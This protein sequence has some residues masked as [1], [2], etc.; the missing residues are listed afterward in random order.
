VTWIANTGFGY[1]DRDELAY[2]E[3][4]SL[5]WIQQLMRGSGD[6]LR[7]ASVSG[8]PLG[9]SI[10]E[11][12][13]QAKLEY[14]NR[15]GAHGFTPYDE[16][17]LGE[18]TLYG[19]PMLRIA[20]PEDVQIRLPRWMDADAEAALAQQTFIS[21]T[22]GLLALR[23]AFTLP[24][25]SRTVTNG[26]YFHVNDET[27]PIPGMP[28]FPRTSVTLAVAPHPG[29]TVIL[30]GRE[31][32]ARGAFL[33]GGR[34]HTYPNVDPAVA[35][36]VTDTSETLPEPRY[37]FAEWVPTSWNLVN[38]VRTE[39]GVQQRL[40]L[41]PAQYSARSAL[42]GT[43]RVFDALTY[44]VYYSDTEDVGPPS[45]WQIQGASVGGRHVVTAE[46]TDLSGVVR[47]AV[48]YTLGEGV[49]HVVDMARTL[50]DPDLWVGEVPDAAE[51]AYFVQAV[52]SAGNVGV[53][54]N[55]GWYFRPDEDAP[56]SQITEVKALD[57]AL[58]SGR[59]AV[60]WT[61]AD[62]GL[63]V[64]TVSL[65]VK[66]GEDATWHDTRQ[67]A[68]DRDGGRFVF[69]PTQGAGTYYFATQAMDWAGNQEP[70]PVGEGMA[71]YDWMP[72]NTL[73]LPVIMRD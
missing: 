5:L 11:A 64:A 28:I 63:G 29:G 8:D 4:L 47:V 1:G 49:W 43:W 58:S 41:L 42:T 59:I 34:Y 56:A 71:T 2:S 54:T 22:M 51:L 68:L 44:T 66:G 52:D 24:V 7:A 48:G 38:S 15:M 73:Y 31:V 14:F 19:L 20:F 32:L 27:Q 69:T 10:G 36:L 62:A 12:L 50:N 35:R 3:Q 57:S 45:F 17:V 65:W 70:A 26:T 18:M 46:V 33:E 9:V 21:D 60:D 30:P 6:P 72:Q 67:W 37:A 53:D 61:A 55:R 16:K 13:R 23:V 40:V 25:A 39:N